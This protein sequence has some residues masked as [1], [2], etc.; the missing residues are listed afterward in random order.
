MTDYNRDR[1]ELDN[2]DERNLNNR[3]TVGNQYLGTEGIGD[4]YE[5]DNRKRDEEFAEE[6]AL[7]NRE[8]GRAERATE[9]KET[10]MRTEEEGGARLGLDRYFLILFRLFY[11]ADYLRG[12]GYSCRFNREKKRCRNAW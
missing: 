11:H 4:E 6:A 2:L 7:Y 3:I 5:P 8:V 1:E 12:S 9:E 10:N